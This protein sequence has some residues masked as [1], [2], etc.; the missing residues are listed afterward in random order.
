MLYDPETRVLLRV[1]PAQAAH[2]QP[3]A[4]PARVQHRA[5]AARVIMIAGQRI[6]LGRSHAGRTV[7]VLASD[8]TVT[9]ELGDEEAG[10][11]RR[12]TTHAVRS[13]IGQRRGPLTPF[14]RPRP[15][16]QPGYG[17]SMDDQ[18]GTEPGSLPAENRRQAAPVESAQ[19]T[20]AGR[21]QQLMWAVPL[22]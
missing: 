7:T 1:H 11:I 19:S 20:P 16:H 13:V 17:C 3:S 2:L 15:V 14:P 18:R 4:E 6:A 12:T 10:V 9:V 21:L 8:T 5:S 22:L